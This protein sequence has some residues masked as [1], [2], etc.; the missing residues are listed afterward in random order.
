[1]VPEGLDRLMVK[2]C[3]T[4]NLWFQVLFNSKKKGRKEGNREKERK[5]KR[6]RKG[7]QL[8]ILARK[9]QCGMYGEIAL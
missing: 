6:E 1:M 5:T 2:E 4:F 3:N 8:F 7:N 9:V